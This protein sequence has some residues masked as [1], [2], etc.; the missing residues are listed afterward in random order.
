MDFVQANGSDKVFYLIG[1]WVFAKLYTTITTVLHEF[2]KILYT[3]IAYTI[4]YVCR[5]Y[6]TMSQKIYNRDFNKKSCTKSD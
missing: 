5:K 4:I 3:K 6:L 2:I 1:F